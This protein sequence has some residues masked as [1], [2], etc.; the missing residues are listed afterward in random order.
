MRLP[1]DIRTFLGWYLNPRGRIKRFGFN[2]AIFLAFLPMLVLQINQGMVFVEKVSTNVAPLMDVVKSLHLL[3]STTGDLATGMTHQK[4]LQNTLKGLQNIGEIFEEK[5]KNSF[6]VLWV[7]IIVF[8]TYI[9]LLPIVQMRLRDMG[10]VKKGSLYFWTALI[11][12]G[13]VTT[14]LKTFGFSPFGIFSPLLI[15]VSF[16]SLAWLSMAK[17]QRYILPSDRFAQKIEP[18]DIKKD[19]F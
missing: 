3:D 5:A 12:A 1:K 10:K 2:I 19:I 11:Y 6:Y 8:L 17:G 14:M 7:D 15:L 9:A 4:S 13:V 16:I 18:Q